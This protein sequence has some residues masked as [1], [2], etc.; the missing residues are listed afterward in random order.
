M[1]EFGIDTEAHKLAKLT[2]PLPPSF[3]VE[4]LDEVFIAVKTANTR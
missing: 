3:T 1:Q 2:E 4:A